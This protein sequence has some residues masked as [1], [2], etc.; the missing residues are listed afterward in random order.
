MQPCPGWT[1]TYTETQDQQELF[2]H[3]GPPFLFEYVWPLV[4]CRSCWQQS[5]FEAWI[6]YDEECYGPL[7][8]CA[9]CNSLLDDVEVVYEKLEVCELAELAAGNLSSR[10]QELQ[11]QTEAELRRCRTHGAT[12]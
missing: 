7:Y 2:D 11:Q 9:S 1:G 8:A 6:T 4:L 3:P 12:V 5:G 10:L